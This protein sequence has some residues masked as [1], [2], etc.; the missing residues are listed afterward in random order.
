MH[1]TVFGASGPT[2][3]LLTRQLLDAGHTVTALVRHPEAAGLSGEGLAVVAGD[4]TNVADTEKALI[5]A[6]A[7]VSVLGTPY[8]RQPITLYSESA[9]AII[10]AMKTRGVRRLVVTSSVATTGWR[11]PAWGWLTRTLVRRLLDTLGGTLYADMAR[12][13]AMVADSGLDWTIMRPLGLANMEPPTEY[14]IA[15]DHISGGQTARRDLAAA[16]VDQLG[17]T[18]YIGKAVA[19]A[20]TNK[21]VSI[22][23]TIWREGIR[24]HLPGLSSPKPA[25]VR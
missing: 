21:T 24:P 14:A 5:S 16:I 11:D 19:V 6:D 23:V 25:S 7:A 17:R 20:T 18:D 4:A 3:R 10:A 15:T 2:G 12:M 1:V 13:E 9:R 22:P 8:S